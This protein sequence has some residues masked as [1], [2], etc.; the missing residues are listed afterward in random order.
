M[1]AGESY[2][3]GG[4][5]MVRN[6]ILITQQSC[7]LEYYVQHNESQVVQTS[8]AAMALMYAQLPDKTPVKRAVELVMSRQYPVSL[9]Q[10]FI[11]FLLISL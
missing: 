5:W 9:H 2:K 7:E 6:W 10:Q 4:Q 1:V 3:A 11:N 8:W